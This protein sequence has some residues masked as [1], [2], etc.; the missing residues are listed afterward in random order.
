MLKF[1]GRFA[2]TQSE[3][4]DYQST[5]PSRNRLQ[6]QRLE[7]PVL[8][9]ISIAA[10]LHFWVLLERIVDVLYFVGLNFSSANRTP[11]YLRDRVLEHAAEAVLLVFA[12]HEPVAMDADQVEAVVAIVDS[13]QISPVRETRV[14]VLA[15]VLEADSTAPFDRVVEP[16]H[17]VSHLVM[18][19]VQISLLV[20]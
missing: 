9:S 19:L 15:K 8:N 4:D 17:D 11:L 18:K 12:L 1:E 3:P 2:S 10:V 13:H 20:S 5:M 16:S 14:L 6:G 7:S